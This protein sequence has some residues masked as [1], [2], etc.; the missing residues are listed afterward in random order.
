MS[1]LYKAA[2]SHYEAKRDEARATLEVYFNKPVGV[3]E[4][5][6]LLEEIRKWAETLAM[7]E[8]TLERL[9][10]NFTEEGQVK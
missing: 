9:R 5:S 3:G 6:D 4:H 1:L 7:A 10:A 2:I 8:D